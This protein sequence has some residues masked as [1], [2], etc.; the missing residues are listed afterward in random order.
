MMSKSISAL[1]DMEDSQRDRY[2]KAVRERW[3]DLFR[4]REKEEW[5][6]ILLALADQN[7]ERLN[8]KLEVHEQNADAQAERTFARLRFDPSPEGEALRNYLIKCTDALF[9]G[10]ANYR[11]YQAATR[12]RRD[13]ASGVGRRGP[14]QDRS[15]ETQG[16]RP[17]TGM[18]RSSGLMTRSG[19]EM[20]WTIVPTGR[21]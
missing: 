8:A 7:I 9:R 2:A 3:P 4:T 15:E 5:R 1:S 13:G 17:T 19:R 20:A 10:M 21:T 14:Q 16:V 11:K 6:Q 12:D 18:V